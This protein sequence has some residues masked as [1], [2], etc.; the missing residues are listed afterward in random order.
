M[1]VQADN[2]CTRST[3]FPRGLTQNAL[4]SNRVTKILRQ[5]MCTETV[6]TVLRCEVLK[7]L[8]VHAVKTRYKNDK[9]VMS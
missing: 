9:H 8:F 7:P 6:R 5:E 2:A 3:W 4:Q 1:H